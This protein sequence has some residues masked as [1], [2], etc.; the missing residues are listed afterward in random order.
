MWN[1]VNTSNGIVRVLDD[2]VLEAYDESIKSY[3]SVKA[4]ESLGKFDK[5][6]GQLMGSNLFRLIQLANSG[7]LPEGTRL[8]RRDDLENAISQNDSFFRGV[9]VDFG[10]ALRTAGDSY[11]PNDLL[12]K[13]LSEQLEQRNIKLGRGKLIPPDSLYLV[14]DG[15]SAYGVVIDLKEEGEKLIRDINDFEW[16]YTRRQGLSRA[17]LGGSKSWGSLDGDLA[18][19]LSTGRVVVFSG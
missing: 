4:K 11:N 17:I 12:A 2:S 18:Y 9:Y 1:Q 5:S 3:N 15:N 7:L 19:S 10:L 6:N 14:E 13:N 8:A 16:N